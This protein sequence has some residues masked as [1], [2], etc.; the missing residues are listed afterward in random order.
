M[1]TT[2]SVKSMLILY[3][4]RIYRWSVQYAAVKP[5]AKQHCIHKLNSD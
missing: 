4:L 5:V 2:F 3:I 1:V